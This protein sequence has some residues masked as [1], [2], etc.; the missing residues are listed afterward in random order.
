MPHIV[1]RGADWFKSI[2]TPK[3]YGPKLYCV[4]GHVNKQVCVELPL[5]VTCR[6]S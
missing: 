4:S 1:E 6:A 5:G 2:G 3:S